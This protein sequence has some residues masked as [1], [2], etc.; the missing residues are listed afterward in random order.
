MTT[1]KLINDPEQ[2]S[3]E[4][5]EGFVA[6]NKDRVRQVPDMTVVARTEAPEQGKVGVVIGGGSGHEPLFLEFVGEGLADAV[7]A[8]AVFTSPG[9]DLILAATKAAHGGAGVVYV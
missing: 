8:G 5:V 9:P 1:K 3:R 7:A 6:L 2:A 4:A